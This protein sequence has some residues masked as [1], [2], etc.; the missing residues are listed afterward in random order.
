MDMA[1]DMVSTNIT[2]TT[3]NTIMD[4]DMAEPQDTEA[5][6]T[7]AAATVSVVFVY[8]PNVAT[9]FLIKQV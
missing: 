2:T 5:G 9:R 7:M 4:K 6:E 8:V 1:E 3:M